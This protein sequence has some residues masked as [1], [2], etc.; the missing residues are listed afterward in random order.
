MKQRA[1]SLI[2][3]LIAL[4]IVALAASL[5]VPVVNGNRDRAAYRVSIENLRQVSKAMENHYLEK[6]VYPVFSDWSQLSAENSPLR[7]YIND[8]PTGDAWG[9]PFVIESSTET[10]YKFSGFAIEGKLSEEYPDYYYIPGPKLKK[11]GQG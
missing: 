3:I 4:A 5:V 9:R 6:G 2:E 8:I 1:F 10:E 7:E 11:K